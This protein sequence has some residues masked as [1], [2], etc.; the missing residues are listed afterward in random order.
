M[1]V[2]IAVVCCLLLATNGI[3]GANVVE[4]TA[5]EGG[6]EDTQS[7]P[8]FILIVADDLGKSPLLS[9]T[10][11]KRCCI[12]GKKKKKTAARK[13]ISVKRTKIRNFNIYK[14]NAIK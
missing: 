3:T 9:V 11:E 8:H 1:E 2:V 5:A 14:K 12:T 6:A 10:I 13:Q 4:D 7:K